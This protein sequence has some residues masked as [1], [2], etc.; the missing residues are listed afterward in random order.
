MQSIFDR[1]LEKEDLYAILN[2]VDS[3]TQEQI[4]TE[5]KLL[6]LRY[7]PDKSPNDAETYQRIKTAYDIVGN[8]ARRA[9]Y[10]RWRLSGL[11]IPFSDYAQLGAHAQTVHWQALPTQA[12]I[13]Q[14]QD[15]VAEENIRS[16]RPRAIDNLPRVTVERPSFWNKQDDVYSK[17]RDY[18]I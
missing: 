16:V 10:D 7:H 17:F 8:P 11:H 18:R 3:S 1:Q 2:C 9:L 12:T 6:A 4:K 13:T 15:T 5:Y 14:S